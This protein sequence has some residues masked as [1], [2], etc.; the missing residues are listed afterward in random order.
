MNCAQYRDCFVCGSHAGS[1]SASEKK[2]GSI[3]IF[4]CIQR[5]PLRLDASIPSVLPDHLYAIDPVQYPFIRVN[6]NRSAYFERCW[7]NMEQEEERMWG[8]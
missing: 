5:L 3:Y 4:F 1:D 6:S 2:I 7:S 8:N